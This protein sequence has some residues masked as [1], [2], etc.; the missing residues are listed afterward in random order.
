MIHIIH[1]GGY[2]AG[3]IIAGL[4]F[5]GYYISIVSVMVF[6]KLAYWIFPDIKP[7]KTPERWG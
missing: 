6:A 2:L 3:F 4:F 1:Q 7:L 5:A